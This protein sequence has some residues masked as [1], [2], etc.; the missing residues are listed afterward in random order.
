MTAPLPIR[1]GLRL[2]ETPTSFGARIA[3]LNGQTLADFCAN[4]GINLGGLANGNAHSLSQLAMLGDVDGKEMR[5]FAVC[6]Q[7]NKQYR[8]AGQLVE[9]RWILRTK[10]RFC[11]QCTVEDLADFGE[12][13]GPVGKAYWH[14]AFL[15]DCGKHCIPLTDLDPERDWGL[16]H[17]FTNRIMRHRFDIQDIAASSDSVA[18]SAL[19]RYIE[20]RVLGDATGGW[21]DGIELNA[22]THF[23]ELLGVLFEFGSD[24]KVQ[25]LT[26]AQRNTAGHVGFQIASKGPKRIYR[27]LREDL[28]AIR[29][30]EKAQGHL[31]SL[32]YWLS[33]SARQPEYQPVKDVMRHYIL[34]NFP[35]GAGETVLGQEVQARQVHSF[36]SFQKECKMSGK[37]VRSALVEHG[38]L[39]LD[40][41]TGSVKEPGVFSATGSKRLMQELN[42]G[43]TRLA[44]SKRLNIPRAQFDAVC[45][46][47]LIKPINGLGK[48]TPHFSA[49]EAD[50]LLS[51]MM[52]NAR[53]AGNFSQEMVDIPTACRKLVCGAAEIIQLIIDQRIQSLGKV[54]SENGYLSLR[55]NVEEATPL[56]GDVGMAGHS[57]A[58][59]KQL[60]SI[61][62]TAVKFLIEARYLKATASRNPVT[63]KAAAVVLPK[64]YAM[65]LK[66]YIPAKHLAE[67]LG[68]TPKSVIAKMRKLGVA[69]LDMPDGC[70]GT[71][72]E[73]EQIVPGMLGLADGIIP[74]PLRCARRLPNAC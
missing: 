8:V 50:S 38:F 28:P 2:A 24:C 67:L 36:G 11:P 66:R 6:R 7:E 1:T 40:P 42:D 17:D 30:R 48:I 52:D 71:M 60:L 4:F 55:I 16:Q 3:F 14:M 21:L 25:S 44:T 19:G 15:R 9:T 43:L 26:K 51:R 45:Q 72:Y 49:E 70:V 64:D 53:P 54:N 37:R 69:P 12:D 68:T 59:L 73:I 22:V 58:K 39:T 35:I 41:V 61:N 32:Y 56:L 10:L 74:N 13:G 23:C 33:Q 63:R 57:K 31:G 65:F 5:R 18:P 34:N 46:A 47:G 29:L 20:A 27:A 62:D